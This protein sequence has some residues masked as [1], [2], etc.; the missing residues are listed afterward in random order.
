MIANPTSSTAA[1]AP[2]AR[3]AR[4]RS[5]AGRKAAKALGVLGALLA[6]LAAVGWIGL[7]V[8]PAPFPAVVPAPAPPETVPLPAGLPAPVERYYRGLYGDRIPVIKSAVITGRGTI[9]PFGVALPMRF[10]FTHEAGRN[11]RHYIETTFFGIP[12]MKVN[13]YYVDGRERMEMPWGVSENNPKLDQGG[14]LGMWAE[15]IMWLPAILLTDPHVRWEPVDDATALLVVPF[16]EAEERFVMRFD[17]QSGKLLYWEVMRYMGGAG[18][19][20]LWING[21]WFEQ[22]KPWLVTS[23]VEVAYN[24]DADVSLDARGP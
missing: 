4:A 24:V 14:N 18:D 1:T 11:E 7:R 13:E 9:A 23:D 22:G 20:T 3:P 19:K 10:R 16:G 8:Q 2:A 21:T 17:S 12:F 6:G 5:G 15:S